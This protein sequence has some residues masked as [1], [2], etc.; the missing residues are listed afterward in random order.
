M[1]S[2]RNA[3][4]LYRQSFFHDIASELSYLFPPWDDLR[5]RRLSANENSYAFLKNHHKAIIAEYT[6]A[7]CEC[8]VC[9]WNYGVITNVMDGSF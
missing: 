5:E 7:L 2:I 4:R 8:V 3:C 1:N 6:I 9:N